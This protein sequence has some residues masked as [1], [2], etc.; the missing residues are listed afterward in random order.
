MTSLGK[1]V[2]GHRRV[3]AFESSDRGTAGTG[4]EGE[5][6]SNAEDV[7]DDQ[8]G[9]AGKE[10]SADARFDAANRQQRQ[11]RLVPTRTP[12]SLTRGHANARRRRQTTVRLMTIPM[13]QLRVR[14]RRRRL[15][16]QG[17]ANA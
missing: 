15:P 10:R 12:V 3:H 17:K 9:E 5:R 2:R 7:E 13:P 4:D 1:Q 6:T 8:L 11:L 14:R 16:P